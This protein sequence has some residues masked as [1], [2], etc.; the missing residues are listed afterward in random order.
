MHRRTFIAGCAALT[1]VPYAREAKEIRETASRMDGLLPF[2]RSVLHHMFPPS[3]SP[4]TAS[5]PA[6][7]VKETLMHPSF[8]KDIRRFVIEG[9]ETFRQRHPRFAQATVSDKD[10][11]L[12]DFERTSY[13]AA[14]LAQLMTLALEGLLSAPVYGANPQ[15]RHWEALHTKGGVPLP[16]TRYIWG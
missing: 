3:S 5:D 10:R 12:R 4:F 6:F 9:T 15:K 1:I 8:D 13:G 14:W 2:L 16:K 11:M 7:F